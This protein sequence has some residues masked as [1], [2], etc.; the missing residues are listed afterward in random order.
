MTSHQN[1]KYKIATR[2]AP[3]Q[4]SVIREMTRLGDETASVNLSQGLP[5]FDSSLDV[6]EAAVKAIRNGDNQYTFPFGTPSFREAVAARCN[7]YNHISADPE[8]EVTITCGVSEA[9]MSAI[10]ALTDPGDEAIILEPWYENY[11]PCCLMAGVRPRFVP[12]REPGYTFDHDELQAAFNDRTRLILINTPHNPT[13]RVFSHAELSTISRLCQTFD[14][15]AVT[16]EIY[17]QILYDG[18]N[19]VSIG[20]L[21][22]MHDRTVTISGL[23]K[24][25]AVTGWRVGWAIAAQ[26]LTAVIRKVHDYLT[27]CAPAPFQAAGIVALGLPEAYYTDMGAQYAA[28]RTI[29]LDA[30]DAVGVPYCKPEGSYYVMADFGN[31]EWDQ[32]AYSN[33]DW[34]TDRAFAEYM[35]R[36]IGVAVVPGSSFYEGND[37]G[38]SR[39]RFNFAKR[40]NTLREAAKRF[41][42]LRIR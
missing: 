38:T 21:E 29:L 34:T 32:G 24:T 23:G 30:L 4:E 6:L 33:P 27:I 11:V 16:D 36:E 8:A 42:R 9:I 35:A 39:V 37:Q 25:Y 40:E 14:V 26:P 19:H 18:H 7:R 12:L 13:G 5:D 10:L 41:Q 31:V 1:S 17:D 28:R 3:F 22:G 15:I 2:T 20:S